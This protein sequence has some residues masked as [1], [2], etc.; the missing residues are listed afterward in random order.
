MPQIAD[1]I[2]LNPAAV[3][4]IKAMV[5]DGGLSA[6][7]AQKVVDVGVAMQKAAAEA[8]ATTVAGWVNELKSDKDFGGANFDANASRIQQLVTKFGDQSVKDI[9]NQSGIG[10]HPGLVRMMFAMSKELLS[11]ASVVTG[12]PVASGA[13]DN[14]ASVLFPTMQKG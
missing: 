12:A 6:E 9:F 1:G 14:T 4:S 5:K 8:H 3:D 11:D 2:E 13:G 7:H 10:N